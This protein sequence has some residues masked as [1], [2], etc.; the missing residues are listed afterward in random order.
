[1]QIQNISIEEKGEKREDNNL[2]VAILKLEADNE[3]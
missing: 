2:Q 3:S 1:M